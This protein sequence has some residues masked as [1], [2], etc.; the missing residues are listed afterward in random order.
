MKR[1][2]YKEVSSNSPWQPAPVEWGL[3]DGTFGSLIQSMKEWLSFSYEGF[4]YVIGNRMYDHFLEDESL[5]IL[6]ME[7]CVVRRRVP[8]RS[9]VGKH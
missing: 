7:K 2:H 9:M 3:T 1:W 5:F 6:E 8:L 4:H